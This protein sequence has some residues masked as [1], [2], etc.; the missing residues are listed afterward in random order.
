MDKINELLDMSGLDCIVLRTGENMADD[1]FYYFTGLDKT[2]N[3][4]NMVVIQRGRKPLVLS[5]VLEYGTLIKNSAFK[6]V[7]IE[8][9]KDVSALFKKLPRKIGINHSGMTVAS[10]RNMR[11][12]SRGKKFIDVSKYLSEIRGTKT[13]DEIKKIKSACRITED[14]FGIVQKIARPGMTEK[15][16]E[17]K[18]R[19]VIENYDTVFSFPPI[20][21]SG[22]N[23]SVPHHI[24]GN[25]KIRKN[26]F[27]L[28]DAGVV[29]SNYCSDITR[30]FFVG[31]AHSNEKNAYDI[32]KKSQLAALSSIKKGVKASEIFNAANSVLKKGLGQSLIHSFGHGLGLNVHDFPNGISSKSNWRLKENMVLTAEPGYYGKRFGIRIED[33]IVVKKSGY[34]FLTKSPKEIVEL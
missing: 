6:T 24:T 27:L 17:K 20:V 31:R 13:Q 14:L 2:K 7:K 15:D 11:S 18:L 23:S 16:I 34:R 29:F 25:K 33:D 10:L 3:L 26:E 8:S 1:N 28:V 30:T 19:V 21:A 32:V 5:D 4:S 12:L 22:V 9:S